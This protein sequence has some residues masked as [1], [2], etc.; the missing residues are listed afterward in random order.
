MCCNRALCTKINRLHE[1]SLQIVSNDKKQNFYELLVKDGSISNHH[2][3]FKKLTV[4]ICKVCRGLSPNIVYELFRFRE[5]I[6]YELRQ[7]PQFQIPW[8]YSGFCGTEFFWA[9]DTGTVSE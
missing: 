7:V 8:G 5:Q 4:E 2:Q 3:N 9:E 1:R 6:P